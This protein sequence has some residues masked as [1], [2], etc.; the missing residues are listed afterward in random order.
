MIYRSRAG[1]SSATIRL[2]LSEKKC[3]IHL[4]KVSTKMLLIDELKHCKYGQIA[5]K[6][7]CNYSVEHHLIIVVIW[8]VQALTLIPPFETKD[9]F[10]RECKPRSARTYVQPNLPIH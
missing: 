10:C 5:R 8:T 1:I 3:L 6:L 2:I 9:L 4:Q 7:Y